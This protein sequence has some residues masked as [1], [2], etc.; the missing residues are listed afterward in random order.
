MGITMLRLGRYRSKG[1]SA[2]F[3]A[4]TDNH[5]LRG[6]MFR[7]EAIIFWFAMAVLVWAT[8]EFAMHF[9]QFIRN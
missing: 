7:T 9:V 2:G 4:E 3:D 6:R 5:P 8:A 1:A